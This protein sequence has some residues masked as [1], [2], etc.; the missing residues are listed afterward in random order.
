MKA[1]IVTW[2]SYNNYGTLLQAFA[3]QQQL[4]RIGIENT[5]LYDRRILEE[6]KANNPLPVKGSQI[7]DSVKENKLIRLSA[8]IHNPRR[9]GKIIEARV[10]R[11]KYERPYWGS[12]DLCNRFK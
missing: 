5:I 3:L 4:N 9:I 6:H 11:T 7:E 10:N 12:Q 2:I 8:L 1:A